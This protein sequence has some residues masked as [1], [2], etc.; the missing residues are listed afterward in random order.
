M[1]KKRTTATQV[2]RIVRQHF[3]D[4]LEADY[5]AGEFLNQGLKR[6]TERPIELKWWNLEGDDG[7]MGAVIS[8]GQIIATV[9]VIR[10]QMNESLM[11]GT[12]FV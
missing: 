4:Q 11:S 9:T 1:A 12:I 6:C 7:R 10:D 3:V 2:H 8:G 5:E